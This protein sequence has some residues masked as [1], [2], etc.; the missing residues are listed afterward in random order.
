M[1]PGYEV[2]I[3]GRLLERG[4]WLYVW[5]IETPEGVLVHVG[6]T[7]DSVN[8]GA[9][10][11][12]ARLG[13]VLDT[14]EQARGNSLARLVAGRGL[15]PL[16]CTYRLLALGPFQPESESM[17]EHRPRRVEMQERA[18]GLCAALEARGLDLVG[19]AAAGGGDGVLPEEELLARIVV[20]LGEEEGGG[21]DFVI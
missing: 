15:E 3:D 19:G 11:V 6:H 9:G 12:V 1:H 21:V 13:A 4:Y 10:T 17:H 16:A 7:G 2:N 8:A 5:K 14:R 20:F 18:A